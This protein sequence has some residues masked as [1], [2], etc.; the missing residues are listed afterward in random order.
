MAG[1]ISEKHLQRVPIVVDDF[2]HSM[3]IGKTGCGKTSSFILPNIVDRIKKG[4][5]IFI[6]DFKGT[7]NSQVKSIAMKENKIQ[8]VIEIGTAWGTSINL[9]QG[10][11]KSLFLE[12]IGIL[13]ENN[14]D[15]FWSTSALN[16]I[17]HLYDAIVL[18]NYILELGAKVDFKVNF[19]Y[20]FKIE[21][22]ITITQNLKEMEDFHEKIKEV[23]HNFGSFISE[24]KILKKSFETIE[25]MNQ[26]INKLELIREYIDNFKRNI[27]ED[28]PAAGSSGVL[29]MAR[30]V[31]LTFEANGLNGDSDIVELLDNGKIVIIQCGSFHPRLN[32]ILM[33]FL[34]TR[35]SK[36][37]K[38]NKNI[39]LFIDE[40]QRTITKESV[41]FVDVFREKK[42]EL[43]AAMQ[44][45]HQ[46]EILIGENE[47]SAFIENILHQF[48]FKEEVFLYEHENKFYRATPLFFTETDNHVA[49]IEWQKTLDKSQQL[50]DGWIY[51]Y[52]IDEYKLSIKN[53][54]TKEESIK[55]RLF[56]PLMSKE[57]IIFQ[58]ILRA[59]IKAEKSR[60]AS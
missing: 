40:F 4:H 15:K 12:G 20:A 45:L 50:E 38:I 47:T 6:I 54:N 17:G 55:Y 58:N 29:F 27:D 51:D 37:N 21:T 56:E 14:N 13:L 43:I 2:R 39:S 23:C 49:Q 41:P 46:L 24:K 5:G 26:Y 57:N 31:L 42:V 9:I 3:C 34:Y 53:I 10:V 60:K 19:P 22:L 59:P 11:S 8:D 52:Q 30:N 48:H 36:R 18:A 16:I 33:H 1:F 32:M 7:L 28:K 35:L 25:I 44:N